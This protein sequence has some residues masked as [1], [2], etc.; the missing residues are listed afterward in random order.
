MQYFITS[1]SSL[2]GIDGPGNHLEVVVNN[3]K[4][5]DKRETLLS[6]NSISESSSSALEFEKTLTSN[7][8]VSA[9][10]NMNRS[11]SESS[12]KLFNFGKRNR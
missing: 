4:I 12:R 11:S 1:L 8:D 6:R 5:K 7:I 10:V 2:E 9:P 3:H